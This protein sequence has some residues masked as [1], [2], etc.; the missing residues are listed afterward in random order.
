M[1]AKVAELEAQAEEM[2]HE[3]EALKEAY[4]KLEAE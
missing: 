4:A 2:R 3:R 1:M